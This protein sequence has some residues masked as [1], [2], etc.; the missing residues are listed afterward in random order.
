MWRPEVRS[1]ASKSDSSV[2]SARSRPGQGLRLSQ[3]SWQTS[4]RAPTLRMRRRNSTGLP[5]P[6]PRWMATLRGAPITLWESTRVVKRS[7]RSR[8][9]AANERGRRVA[10]R[11]S[12]PSATKLPLP[13]RVTM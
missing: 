7:P 11:G 4:G 3:L 8:K 2:K 13:L 5:S 9:S 12:P 6:T 1:T 10:G